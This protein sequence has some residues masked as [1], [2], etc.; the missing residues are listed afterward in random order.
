MRIIFRIWAVLLIRPPYNHVQRGETMLNPLTYGF[1]LTGT[2]L[3]IVILILTIERF[4]IKRNA[5]LERGDR[6]HL[7]LIRHL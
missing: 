3:G 2:V 1:L 7:N 5:S 6:L 4:W